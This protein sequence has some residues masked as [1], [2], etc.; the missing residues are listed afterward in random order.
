MLAHP[1]DRLLASDCIRDLTKKEIA[2]ARAGHLTA[3][4]GRTEVPA[5]CR[6]KGCKGKGGKKAKISL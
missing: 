6:E 4:T 5:L 1:G 3:T 2:V